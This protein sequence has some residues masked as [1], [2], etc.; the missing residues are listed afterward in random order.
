MLLDFHCIYIYTLISHKLEGKKACNVG[1]IWRSWQN[2]CPYFC[3]VLT[4]AVSFLISAILIASIMRASIYSYG[5]NVCVHDNRKSSIKVLVSKNLFDY[6]MFVCW[7]L[8]IVKLTEVTNFI[9]SLQKQK[10]PQS[11]IPML[12][13][14]ECGLDLEKNV[15][16]FLK[17]RKTGHSARTTASY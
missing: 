1:L 15:F 2:K 11:K 17:T 5:F 10:R 16:I 14:Q 8:P 7:Y 12:F 4:S 6:V 9:W 3:R 13:A